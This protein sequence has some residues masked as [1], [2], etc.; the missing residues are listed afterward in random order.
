[1]TEKDENLLREVFIIPYFNDIMREMRAVSQPRFKGFRGFRGFRGWWYR[2]S[3]DEFYMPPSAAGSLRSL[4][5][6]P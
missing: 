4:P 5:P 6:F 3:G 1:M 2:P